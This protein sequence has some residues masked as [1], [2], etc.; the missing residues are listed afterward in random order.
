MRKD[1]YGRIIPAF[2]QTSM[3]AGAV[4]FNLRNEIKC[5]FHTLKD[6]G[7]ECSRMFG[8]NRYHFHVQLVLF[9]HNIGYLL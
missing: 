9:M 7:L 3:G 2:L 1:S 6:K 8:Y 5:L 4:L